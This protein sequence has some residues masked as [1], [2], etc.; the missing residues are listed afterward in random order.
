M[1]ARC[2]C[3][4]RGA[5]CVVKVILSDVLGLAGRRFLC[6]PGPREAEVPVSLLYF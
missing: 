4:V 3:A 5:I 2:P 6:T 1:G